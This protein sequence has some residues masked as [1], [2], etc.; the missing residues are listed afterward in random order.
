MPRA[1]QPPNPLKEIL[2]KGTKAND[3][4]FVCVGTDR[5]TG[6][7]L[8]PMIGTI[9]KEKGYNV[10]G[11]LA[12]PVNAVNL[13][14]TL[15]SLPKNKI[16]IGVDASLGRPESVGK[17]FYK[18][19]PLKPGAGV[20]KKLPEVGDYHLYGVVNVGGFM[21]YFVLQNTRLKLIMDMA[22]E[23]VRVI[24]KALPKRRKKGEG[25]HTILSQQLA[26]WYQRVG[27]S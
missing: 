18:S 17:L 23:A 13:E 1:K 3:V 5:S 27:R 16:V 15:R 24:T 12:E 10:V 20:N 14:E 19:G 6:D 22:D 9:L 8:G 2:P 11:T 21:E 7:S 4:M 25:V 26:F